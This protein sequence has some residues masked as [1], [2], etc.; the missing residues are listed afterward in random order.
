VGREMRNDT[1]T[2]MFGTTSALSKEIIKNLDNPICFGRHNVDY[3]DPQHFLQTHFSKEEFEKYPSINMYVN[4]AIDI[5]EGNHTETHADFM[6]ILDT[7]SINIYFFHRLLKILRWLKKP[8]KVCYITSSSPNAVNRLLKLTSEEK[9]AEEGIGY[10]FIYN[11][12]RSL[13]QFSYL[14]RHSKFC[15]TIGVSPSSLSN[16]NIAEYGRI[17]AGLL[18]KDINDEQWEKIYD[19][20]TGMWFEWSNL[21]FEPDKDK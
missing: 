14:S 9:E 8:V 11:V 2:W 13:Q 1:K 3:N 21:K 5:P 18:D 10:M 7:V 16:E 4:V 20:S 6:K 19:L 17:I 12:V 15:R